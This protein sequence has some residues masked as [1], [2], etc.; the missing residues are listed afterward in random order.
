MARETAWSSWEEWNHVKNLF[1]SSDEPIKQLEAIQFVEMWKSRIRSGTLPVSIELTA[2]LIAASVQLNKSDKTSNRYQTSLSGAMALVRFVNGITDHF[3]TG[4]YAQSV[5]TIA[6]KINIPDWLVDL[7]HEITHAQLPSEDLINSGIMVALNW[8]YE[9]YWEETSNKIIEQQESIC[10]L[11]S[12]NVNT[13]GHLIH[14]SL[15][16]SVSERPS[17]SPS[18]NKKKP[19]KNNRDLIVQNILKALNH[20]N[21]KLVIYAFAKCDMFVLSR[22]NLKKMGCLFDARDELESS[23]ELLSKYAFSWQPLL[24]ALQEKCNTFFKS[25]TLSIMGLTENEACNS[26]ILIALHCLCSVHPSAVCKIVSYLLKKPSA[27]SFQILKL[28]CKESKLDANIKR[29]VELILLTFGNCVDTLSKTSEDK[30]WKSSMFGNENIADDYIKLI[31]NINEGRQS[32]PGVRSSIKANRWQCLTASECQNIPAMGEFDGSSH[33]RN[34]DLKSRIVKVLDLYDGIES[35]MVGEVL[36]ASGD[37]KQQQSQYYDQQLV[38][39]IEDLFTDRSVYVEDYSSDG[40]SC[41]TEEYNEDLNVSWYDEGLTGVEPE[42]KFLSSQPK[43][44]ASVIDVSK[45]M[46]F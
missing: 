17:I 22:E 27:L 40:D 11:F 3:Q 4:L 18:S 36:G 20:G 12:D 37:A 26:S 32:N 42:E 29:I 31:Q 28:I 14:E 10:K 6:E 13:Y 16:G 44:D 19:K 25:L 39:V 15:F 45:V 21:V 33:I 34:L 5:Q 23:F 24:L 7:R 38:D 30:D 2:T 41:A 46:F 35:G 9:N 8:L 43:L 1:F